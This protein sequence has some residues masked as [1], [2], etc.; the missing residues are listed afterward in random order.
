MVSKW[1]GM[2]LWLEINEKPFEWAL[3]SSHQDTGYFLLWKLDY[4]MIDN[5]T[6]SSEGK[7]QPQD[8]ASRKILLTSH[9]VLLQ[10]E[11][12]LF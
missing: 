4:I 7:S 8:F 2:W 11:G 9:A 3:F 6:E 12:I 10:I 1:N 5:S